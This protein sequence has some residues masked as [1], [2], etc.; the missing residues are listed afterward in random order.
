MKRLFSWLLTI[1][2]CLQLG[3][4]PANGQSISPSSGEAWD[5][6]NII[7]TLGIEVFQDSD[8]IGDF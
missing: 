1:V 6:N 4:V 3:W 5:K 8:G 7:Y 2:C